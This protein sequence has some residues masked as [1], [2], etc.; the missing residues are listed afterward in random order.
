[1]KSLNRYNVFLSVNYIFLLLLIIASCNVDQHIPPAEVVITEED[2]L[3]I[4]EANYLN[5]IGIRYAQLA[6]ERS[7]NGLILAYAGR[8][9]GEYTEAANILE[10]LAMD[11]D[12]ALSNTIDGEGIHH[13]DQ[14]SGLSG[15]SF[16]SLYIQRNIEINIWAQGIMEGHIGRSNA[17]VLINYADQQLLLINQRLN[18]ALLIQ[19]ELQ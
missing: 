19:S 9:I 14:I 17:D 11:F 6:D 2:E 4:S 15:S 18:D 13:L 1:M 5:Q 3:F 12:L 7:E 8:M 16:D 10:T